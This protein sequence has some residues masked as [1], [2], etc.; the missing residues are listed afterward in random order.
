MSRFFYALILISLFSPGLASAHD[1]PL[2]SYGCHRNE[3]MGTYHCHLGALAQH[4]FKSKANMLEAL[5][6]IKKK[7]R[8]K[9]RS[10]CRN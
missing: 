6:E 8:K 1:G 2:D 7:Q 5:K 3:A 4:N 10:P 9:P